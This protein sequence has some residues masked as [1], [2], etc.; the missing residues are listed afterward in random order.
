MNFAPSAS[1]SPCTVK[2]G[3]WCVALDHGVAMRTEYQKRADKNFAK[4]IRRF[5]F[6]LNRHDEDEARI[7]EHLEQ[8]QNKT[9]YLKALIQ[10]DIQHQ[11]HMS[12]YDK[13]CEDR[14]IAG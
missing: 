10:R 2:A 6:D 4:K 14:G 3:A 11:K 12:E 13:E 9:E 7:I 8:Q 1:Q 5:V